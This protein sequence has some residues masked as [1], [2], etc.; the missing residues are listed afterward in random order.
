MCAGCCS[1]S[2]TAV[3]AW[4]QIHLLDGSV[5]KLA[6]KPTTTVAAVLVAVRHSVCRQLCARQRAA[7]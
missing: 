2:L 5:I 6:V 7:G 1:R 4:W 3:A